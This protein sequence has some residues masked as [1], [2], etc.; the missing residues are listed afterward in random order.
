LGASGRSEAHVRAVAS[1][2]TASQVRVFITIAR[3]GSYSRAAQVLATAEPSLHRVARDLEHSLG[4]TLYFRSPSGIGTNKAG[5]E[6]ARRWALAQLEIEQG[7][8]EI[9]A[10]EGAASGRVAIGSL[11]LARTLILPRAINRA[12]EA[13]P[14]ANFVIVDGPYDTL[15]RN[16]RE[17][18]TDFLVGAL[19][20]P[21]P[22]DDIVQ[23]ELLCDPY[24]VVARKGHPLFAKRQISL[25]DLAEFKWV[26]PRQGTPVRKA[27]EALF[28]EG[29]KP[30]ANIETSSLVATRGI[31]LESNRLTL[32]S[33]RQI[34]IEERLDLLRVLPFPLLETSRPVG[35]TTRRGWLPSP[36][37]LTFLECLEA[38]AGEA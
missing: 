38:A 17:G 19:R 7:I 16:L 27:F 21:P 12:C 10:L 20:L 14:N 25:C 24:A 5:L 23:R 33:H 32:L 26:I 6:L 30:S 15:V 1:R 34:A 9:R 8:D 37:H 36:V 13:H 22:F 2:L 11:P 31:L 29:S 3:T 4:R 18:V 28:A 35:V